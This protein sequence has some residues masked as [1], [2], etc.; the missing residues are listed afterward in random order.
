MSVKGSGEGF[1]F[2]E[3]IVEGLVIFWHKKSLLP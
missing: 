2:R 1:D 3:S